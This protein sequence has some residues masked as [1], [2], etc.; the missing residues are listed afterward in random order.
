VSNRELKRPLN[1]YVRAGLHRHLERMWTQ[2]VELY[3]CFHFCAA[4]RFFFG[5][6]LSKNISMPGR[7]RSLTGAPVFPAVA[8]K[9]VAGHRLNHQ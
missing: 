4:F 7:M 9:P 5:A 2:H 3:P 8:L 6:S 1:Q